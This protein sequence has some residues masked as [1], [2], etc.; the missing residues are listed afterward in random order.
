MNLTVPIAMFGWIPLVLALFWFLRPRRAVLAGFL[1]GW[2]FLPITEYSIHGWPDYTKMSAVCFGILVAVALF[3]F[4]HLISLRPAWIDAP[5]LLLC[6]SPFASS[7][8]NGL[9]V[10]E[11]F[12]VV[13]AQCITWGIPY[14]LG[15]LYFAG[16]SSLRELATGIF[17]A[18][19]LYAPLVLLEFW[20]GPFLHKLIY[21]YP[22]P[23]LDKLPRFGALRPIVFMQ[24]SLMLA[25][26]MAVAAVIG[27]WLWRARAFASLGGIPLKWLVPL[28]VLAALAM[29]SV[30]A[31][32]LLV[33]G[34]SLLVATSV[35]N[36]RIPLACVIGL[37]LVFLTIRVGGLWS[38]EQ[39]VA[40]VGKLINPDRAQSIAYRFV[41]EGIIARNARERPVLG[42]GRQ[43]RAFDARGAG[44][45]GNP[46]AVPDSAWIVVFAFYGLAGLIGLIALLLMPLIRFLSQYAPVQWTR[47]EIAPA[48]AL[49][50]ALLLY[51]IDSML[52]GFLNPIFMLVAG[53]LA[54]HSSRAI[55][56][57]S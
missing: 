7:L 42:W 53:G 12:S 19:V 35:L 17:G 6:L 47:P 38:G 8:R 49:A 52:N 28:P 14:A 56:E 1:I 34:V 10:H 33:I 9:G 2:M 51:T 24:G 5:V 29:R 23:Q 4:R 3:D 40:V 13:F 41:N 36:S 46:Y 16:L 26:W 11:G 54:G 30:N 48:A 31:W 44:P 25:V 39:A 18:G 45:Y 37:I 32:A 20:R 22:Q 27:I 50:V 21:G 55:F 15:R 57:S 43:Q